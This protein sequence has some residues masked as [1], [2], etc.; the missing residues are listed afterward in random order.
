MSAPCRATAHGPGAF[1][2]QDR[3]DRSGGNL[4]EGT[5]AGGGGVND[6]IRRD[7]EAYCSIGRQTADRGG[8]RFVLDEYF[9][10][11]RGLPIMM[12]RAVLVVLVTA[13]TAGAATIFVAPEGNDA[14]SGSGEKRD[15][16][17]GPKAT[18]AA[19]LEATRVAR[20]RQPAERVEIRLRGGRH[21]LKEAIRITPA[22]SN[23]TIAAY[24]NERPV[25]S[26][27]QRLAGWRKVSDAS[28][29][30]QAKAPDWPFR[31]LFINGQRKQRARTPNEG[32]YRIEGASSQDK[33]MKLKFKA[34]NIRP[35]WAE[36]GDVEVVGL[37]A[38]SDVRMFIRAVDEANSVATLSGNPRPSNREDNARYYI[39]NAP[40]GLDAPGEWHL[41]ATRRIVTYIAQPGEDL[42]KAEVIASRLDDLLVLEGEAK[43]PVRNVKL[44][45]LTFSHTDWNPGTNGYAD[46][47]AAV[48]IRGDIRAEFAVHCA[49]EGCTFAQLAGYALELGRGCQS[50]RVAGNEMADIGA[51][52][53]RIGET[54]KRSEAADLNHSHVITDNHMHDLG[55]VY[56]PAVGVFIMQSG[57]NRVAHNHIHHLYYT[58]VS[59][60]WNWGY[61]ETPCRENIIEFNHLHDVGQGMLSDMGAVYTLGIQKGTV[62]RNNLIHDVNSFSYGGWGLYTDEGSSDI[63]LENNVVYRTKSAGFHQHYGRDNIVRNNI[64]AFGKEY[65]LMRTREEAH[66]SFIFTNNIVYFD[67]GSLL[68]S[69]WKNE[70]F[71]IDGNIYFDA[72]PNA[73]VKFAGASFEEWKAR[74]HDTN[75]V[76][77]DPGFQD[78]ARRNFTLKPD[79]VALQRGFKP[80]DRRRVGVRPRSVGKE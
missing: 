17:N 73:V 52:G 3:V 80:I 18:I 22:D 7:V 33:P 66:I 64:F 55:V 30:W 65:Q 9:G 12:L 23:L 34:G 47:Q 5:A 41:D 15:G 20:A 45:G 57:T 50:F 61:Q 71:V 24:A 2:G 60:G 36:R 69:S 77:A 6:S 38:W 72:R 28:G 78:P 13:C 51:G 75:S 25:V 37:F 46:S 54:T 74:G 10:A 44:Q 59:V 19:A 27:G 76:I 21:P 79:S 29:R 43:N 8:A 53:V 1:R 11:G 14:W 35:E 49:T 63:V 70:K 4:H 32:F 42:A 48:A 68:G 67:S 16:T 26:G 58:A 62:I 39:E 40:D 56:A 31:S